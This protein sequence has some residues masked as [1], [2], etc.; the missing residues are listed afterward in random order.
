MM[1]IIQLRCLKKQDFHLRIAMHATNIFRSSTGGHYPSLEGPVVRLLHL[2]WD[3]GVSLCDVSVM[4]VRRELRRLVLKRVEML[5]DGVQLI[6]VRHPP[7]LPLP[8]SSRRS[9]RRSSCARSDALAVPTCLIVRVEE[10]TG[11]PR[12]KH[13]GCV[14][15][16]VCV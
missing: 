11:T 4:G 2:K 7:C 10:F 1:H 16:C 6:H 15:A 3:S 12:G 5:A 9:S 8:L 14:C 13:S